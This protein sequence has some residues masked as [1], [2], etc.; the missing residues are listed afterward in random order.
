M[1]WTVQQ[2]GTK[3]QCIAAVNAIP[4]PTGGN[5]INHRAR[6]VSAIITEINAAA[7]PLVSVVAY[8]DFTGQYSQ[9]DYTVQTIPGVIV[10]EIASTP[11]KP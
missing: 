7:G 4:V 1:A 9:A 5:A 2:N 11:N 6:S 8:G 10:R 3:A